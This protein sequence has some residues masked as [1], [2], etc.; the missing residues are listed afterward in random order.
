MAAIKIC[1][2]SDFPGGFSRISNYAMHDMTLTM[3][4][5]GLLAFMMSLPDGWDGTAA[6]L[7]DICIE[8]ETAISSMLNE[9][10][11]HGYLV[12]VKK[13]PNETK[14]GR[15]EY[16]YRIYDIPQ[17]TAKKDVNE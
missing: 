8:G 9:L 13:F 2:S 1:K 6:G 11:Q 10:E 15:I 5:R 17:H 12:R 4:A 14:S 3:K 7:A 16:E